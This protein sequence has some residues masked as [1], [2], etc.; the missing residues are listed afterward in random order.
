MDR[1]MRDARKHFTR[2]VGGKNFM[3]PDVVEYGWV[4]EGEVSYEISKGEGLEHQDIFGITF[5]GKNK[6]GEDVR[7][8]SKCQASIE[9]ARQYI[10]QIKKI[11]SSL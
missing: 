8:L 7:E 5:A 6:L 3:T 4:I 9:E 2:V 10:E 11:L 1:E